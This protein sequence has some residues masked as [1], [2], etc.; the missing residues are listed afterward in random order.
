M[1][2]TQVRVRWLG[3]LPYAEAWDLQK[4][5]WEGRVLGRTS[6]DYLLLLEHPHVFTHGPRSILATN[7]R[8]EPAAV[9]VVGGE[10]PQ[11]RADRAPR[12]VD[13]GDDHQRHVAPLQLA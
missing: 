13:A 5:F 8:C 10:V 7:L 3:R 11:G 6:D 9:V 4:A 1:T 12:R 2:K